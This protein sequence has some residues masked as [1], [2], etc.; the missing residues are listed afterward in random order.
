MKVP[1]QALPIAAS[2]IIVLGYLGYSFLSGPRII[3][4]DQAVKIASKVIDLDDSNLI[5]WHMLNLSGTVLNVVSWSSDG[6]ITD[7]VM[8]DRGKILDI[9]CTSVDPKEYGSNVSRAL[10]QMI[11]EDFL[12]KESGYSPESPN[13]TE[14]GMKYNPRSAIWNVYWN[15]C[16]GNF[17]IL[18][19]YFNVHV[20]GETGSV[21]LMDNTLDEVPFIEPPESI[22]L[23]EEDAI[24]IA[25]EAYNNRLMNASYTITRTGLQIIQDLDDRTKYIPVRIV[26]ID[27]VG[28]E[29]QQR[30]S[31]AIFYAIDIKTGEIILTSSTGAP[32]V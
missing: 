23:S 10:I 1:R 7:V 28:I 15:R 14:I 32:L 12:T 2:F 19:A 31:L 22:V 8:D 21:R 25:T 17:T 4:E 29:D 30:M 26:V 20:D 9:L 5:G 24:A 27:G 13:L 18:N 16:A 11:A 3:D 6:N